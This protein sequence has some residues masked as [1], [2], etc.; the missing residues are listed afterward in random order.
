[1]PPPKDKQSDLLR[2]SA[3]APGNPLP[4]IPP[5]CVRAILN[6]RKQSNPGGQYRTVQA[7]GNLSPPIYPFLNSATSH[8]FPLNN[9]HANIYRWGRKNFSRQPHINTTKSYKKSQTIRGGIYQNTSSCSHFQSQ[10]D[11][12]IRTPK[13][14]KRRENKKDSAVHPP[15]HPNI[16]NIFYL[17]K[18]LKIDI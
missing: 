4:V 17:Y 1:M 14:K 18:Y 16:T 15:I 11:G 2:V 9:R 12:Y 8:L 10:N 7:R 13:R 5:S 6:I 3:K